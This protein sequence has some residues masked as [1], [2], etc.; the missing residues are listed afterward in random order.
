[1][2]DCL[3]D[4]PF[5]TRWPNM[6]VV[7]PLASGFL[8]AAVS[9]GA[10]LDPLPSCAQP[11]VCSSALKTRSAAGVYCHSA[12]PHTPRCCDG[13]GGGGGAHGTTEAIPQPSAALP[14]PAP[15]ASA[16]VVSAAA[17]PVGAAAMAVPAVAGLPHAAP[18]ASTA[19][20][21]GAAA[22]VSEEILSVL[23]TAVSP[24]RRCP[25]P[26]LPHRLPHP[27]ANA[28]R[29]STTRP[30]APLTPRPRAPRA[31]PSPRS[32]VT[33][34]RTANALTA[35]VRALI[36]AQPSEAARFAAIRMAQDCGA[37][38]DNPL[39]LARVLE[40]SSAPLHVPL[41]FE[42]PITA[43][44]GTPV[45]RSLRFVPPERCAAPLRYHR[46]THSRGARWPPFELAAVS[47]AASA[48]AF[49][50]AAVGAARPPDAGAVAPAAAGPAAAAAAVDAGAGASDSTSGAA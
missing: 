12:G 45:R 47:G 17:A 33:R 1:V 24:A 16:P 44:T 46:A 18:Y 15:P 43:V 30:S 39:A 2:A 38:S 49:G 7:A 8:I 13:A 35:G 3:P 22:E 31:S 6:F 36:A 50:D 40:Y 29:P 23:M 20:S 27:F 32:G 11:S 10:V 9:H 4:G 28:A 34:W 41:A 25:L 37:T 26:P 5:D 48:A 19:A 42:P 21:A 14:S